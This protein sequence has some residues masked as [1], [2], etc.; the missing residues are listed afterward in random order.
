[1][2]PIDGMCEVKHMFFRAWSKYEQIEECRGI[3]IE[4][5]LL[6]LLMPRQVLDL[7]RKT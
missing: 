1:M 2:I 6:K 3:N 7:N 5:L 4:N